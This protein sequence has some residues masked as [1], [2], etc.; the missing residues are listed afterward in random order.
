M[1]PVRSDAEKFESL[2]PKHFP[3]LLPQ[4]GSYPL[5]GWIL[6]AREPKHEDDGIPFCTLTPLTRSVTPRQKL[7]KKQTPHH[8]GGASQ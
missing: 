1:R 3:H 4:F 6:L 2:A 5:D 8:E 7:E